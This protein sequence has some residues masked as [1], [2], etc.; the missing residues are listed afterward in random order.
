[1]Q[2]SVNNWVR[3]NGQQALQTE[4]S[5]L[6]AGPQQMQAYIR[7]EQGQQRA[8][9]AVWLG[10]QDMGARGASLHTAKALAH[11]SLIKHCDQ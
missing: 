6:Q 1:M 2:S 9:G 5:L 10:L 3:Q 4:V 8:A 11:A 7:N